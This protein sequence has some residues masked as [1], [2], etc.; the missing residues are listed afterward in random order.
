M[1]AA[2]AGVVLAHAAGYVAVFPDGSER[3]PHLAATGHAYWPIAVALAVAAATVA[4]LVTAGRGAL[5]AGPPAHRRGR[6]LAWLLAWQGTA[7]TVMEVGERAVSSV[8]PS[9]LLSSPEFWLGLA[10]QLP[11]A[12]LSLRLLG[13]VERAAS[14]L[15]ANLR[16]PAG[17]RST[18]KPLPPWATAD[19][20]VAAVASPAR[21]RAPPL[22][23]VCA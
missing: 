5:S 7:F 23:P 16:P 13:T 21:P 11:V 15:A 4:L 12:L 8:A 9:A 17:R 18:A 6:D 19:P 2:A 3:G 22:V 20:V 1:L 14:R 10:L